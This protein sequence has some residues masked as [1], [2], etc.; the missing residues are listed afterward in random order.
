M[1]GGAGTEHFW[2]SVMLVGNREMFGER[3]TSCAATTHS[4]EVTGKM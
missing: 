3:T 4:V 1:C 2:S